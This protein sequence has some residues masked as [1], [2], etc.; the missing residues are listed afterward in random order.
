MEHSGLSIH[1]LYVNDYVQPL[2]IDDRSV[3]FSWRLASERRGA[4]QTAYR[5]LVSAN[6]Q[7]LEQGEGSLWDSG[8]MEG[9]PL[10]VMY[11][12]PPLDGHTRYWWKAL[13]WDD[14]GNS[15]ESEI[16]FF[17]TGLYPED[18]K[19]NWIWKP[20][21]ARINDFA[22]FRKSFR[23]DKKIGLAK[24]FASA[25]HFMQL[26]V[27]GERVGGY[28]SPAPTNPLRTK[29]YLAY[30]VTRLLREGDNCIAAIV[31]Y[32]GGDGQNYVNGA[33]GFLLQAEIA[34]ADGSAETVITDKTWDT[35]TDIPHRIGTRYQQNRRISAIESYDARKADESWTGSEYS[36]VCARAVTAGRIEEQQWRV[37]WQTIPE[38]AVEETIVPMPM[39]VQEIGRQVFDT[40]KIVSGWPRLTVKGIRGTKIRMR[41]SEDLDEQGYVKHNVSNETSDYYYDEYTM[42]G[43]E[44]ETWEPDLSYKAFRYIEVTGYPELLEA[45]QVL[46]VSAHT[47]MAYEG[48]FRSSSELLNEMYDACI[49]TQKNNAL[50]QL[51]DCPHREQAQY[52]ADSDLQAELLL[53]Q[54]DSARM[55]EKVLADFADGQ[56]ADGTFPFVYPS[57]YEH[58]DF[59]IRIPEWD[60]HFPTIL[61]KLYRF[62]G[63]IRTLE[64]LY[65]P[66][67]RMLVHYFDQTDVKLGLVPQSRGTKPRDWHIS[68]HPYPEIDHS[69]EF[70][71][72]QNMKLAH[73]LSL[74]A[75]IAGI[76]GYESEAE[77]MT[78]RSA[79]MTGAI[80]SHL[81]DTENKRFRDSYGV[82][83]SHQGTNAVAMHYGFVPQADMEA[84]LDRIEGQGLETKT[85]LS[86]N[87]LHV[88]FRNGRAEAGYRLLTKTDFPSWGYMIRQGSRTI[89]EGFRDIESHCHAWNA[90]P[91]RMMVEYVAGIRTEETGW[92]HIG[93]KP[94]VPSDLDYAEGRV[95]TLRGNVSAAWEK[96]ADG[97]GLRLNVDVPVGSEASVWIPAGESGS[98]TVWESG[99][100]VWA[101]HAFLGPS[102]G[103]EHGEAAE[104]SVVLRIRS[105]SY[106]FVCHPA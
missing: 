31:H 95:T 59:H 5:V 74:M 15:A 88:L 104:G 66:A 67:K 98:V 73:G 6:L 86:L 87:L 56:L 52:L 85:L 63:D 26:Y 45:E 47:A 82:E 99:V 39:P 54:F 58:P 43:A 35:L 12:G 60:L 40:G 101:E 41:Y 33:P 62:S 4:E 14:S 91:A 17:D 103:I 44:E 83:S 3:A 105:G 89:W 24:I 28:G 93:I 106:A 90:Y 27:N 20:G 80:Q 38:G 1:S 9:H 32:L 42:C 79:F 81:Y 11:E 57:N 37:R 70:L 30:D 100:P 10:R 77:Q 19:A 22:Y 96:T 75:E 34:F 69:G 7:E 78:A 16:C 84:L 61:W 97:E 36:G 25:H 55:V 71:T 23:L 64:R 65:A 18:W 102:P 13:V 53:Y 49:Q 29:Y 46:I 94:F 72:V 50:G 76:L 51:V 21:E 2:G 48:G 8:R 92:T 68:D